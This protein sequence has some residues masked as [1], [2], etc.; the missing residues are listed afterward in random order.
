MNPI[1][2]ILFLCGII[3]LATFGC[4]KENIE[5]IELQVELV[6]KNNEIIDGFEQG[7]TIFFNFYL[8]NNTAQEISYLDPC[9]EFA[10]FFTI[11]KENTDN[12]KYQHIGNPSFVCTTQC[13][14]KKIKNTEKKFI[15]YITMLSNDASWWP[16]MIPGNYYVGDTLNLSI[17]NERHIFESKIY[18]TIK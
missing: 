7:D 12:G 8:I 2:K 15:N 18:F 11:Y 4:E 3:V 9:N 13:F 17:D 16:E 5:A 14:Y 6:N 10:E 1:T